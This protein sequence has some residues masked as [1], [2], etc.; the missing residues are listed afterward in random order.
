MLELLEI[1]FFFLSVC[2]QG[3]GVL[4]CGLNFF[5]HE[6]VSLHYKNVKYIAHINYVPDANITSLHST[7]VPLRSAAQGGN[8]KTS[9]CDKPQE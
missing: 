5:Y 8:C 3:I 9:R 6:H 7:I 1:S 2:V 4:F